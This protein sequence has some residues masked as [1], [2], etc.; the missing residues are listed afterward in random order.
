MNIPKRF[1]ELP[2]FSLGDPV[3]P[4]AARLNLSVEQI[5]KLDANENPYGISPRA[6]NALSHLAFP[7]LYPDPSSAALR[8][9]L[10]G[11]SG[12]PAENLM[13]GAGADE[14]IEF[15]MKVLLDAGDRVLICPPTFGMYAL[16]ARIYSG[17]VVECPRNSD[18]SLNLAGIQKMVEQQQPKILFVTSP[19]NPDGRLATP[20][21]LDALL[22][23][24]VLVV[25]D[26]AYIEFAEAA[27]RLGKDLTR[28][29]QV[30]E[31]QNL[32]VL[33][34][35]SKW[36]GLAGLRVGYG[37]FPDWLMPVLWK[38]KP[39]YN[40]NVAGEAAA[41]AS[42]DDLDI[43]IE[44]IILLQEERQ[45]LF[46]ELSRIPY[47][48]PYPSKANFILCR[49]DGRPA[50]QLKADLAGHGILVR[51]FNTPWLKDCIRISI[52]RP[53]DSERLLGVLEKL[54]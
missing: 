25:L 40:I 20:D 37:A 34:T 7:N 27:N 21:E 39:P 42:L 48:K 45:S 19:N 51:Y 38:A 44:R 18:F 11:L 35:F 41:L 54:I 43:L 31:R 29:R 23:L 46:A 28:I 24:P 26:E 17:V 10:S 15:L 8:S 50:A 2:T 9:A 16:D 33:R 52:G 30:P 53:E 36:A 49:V 22:E 1:D 3:R 4:L 6:L 13:V 32:V 14:L 12:V 47:L 5:V